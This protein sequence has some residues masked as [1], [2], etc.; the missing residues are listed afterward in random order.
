E[1]RPNPLFNWAQRQKVPCL[2]IPLSVGGRFSVLTAVGLLP[3]ALVGLNLREIE[4]GVRSVRFN[5][6]EWEAVASAVLASW[7][8]E[9]WITLLWTYGDGLRPF[10]QWLQ[11]LWAESLAKAVDRSG[12]PA[13]RVSFPVPCVGTLDQHSLLQQVTEGARDKWVW[14]L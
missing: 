6:P 13:P 12:R 10:T 4:R 3:A 14:I 11:Q 9:E 1:L 5:E 8:R 7:G 2:E